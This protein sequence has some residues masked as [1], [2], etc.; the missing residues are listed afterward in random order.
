MNT[1]TQ[2]NNAGGTG[3]TSNGSSSTAATATGASTD[4]T[5]GGVTAAVADPNDTSGNGVSGGVGLRRAFGPIVAQPLWY[6][7]HP[8]ENL[9]RPDRPLAA[10]VTYIHEDV[11][12]PLSVN[13]SV[14]DPRGLPHSRTFVPFHDPYLGADR[15]QAPL[16]EP[17]QK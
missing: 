8:G 17:A 15:P 1:K 2:Q 9:G 13:L 4:D 5:N 3:A 14:L 16:C 7:P 6:W 12:E 10:I 11:N